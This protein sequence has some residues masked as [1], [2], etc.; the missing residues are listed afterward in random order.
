[1]K[2]KCPNCNNQLKFN[3]GDSE[4]VCLQCGTIITDSETIQI[5]IA[6]YQFADDRYVNED[7]FYTDQ[8]LD[9]FIK[10]VKNNKEDYISCVIITKKGE[11]KII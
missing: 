9:N 1:M 8:E 11:N 6:K 10:Y 5:G 3:I 7:L 2:I 4:I